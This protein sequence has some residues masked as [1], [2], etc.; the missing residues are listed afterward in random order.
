MRNPLSKKGYVSVLVDP[1]TQKRVWKHPNDIEVNINGIDLKLGDVLTDLQKNK[2][3][4]K[5]FED[6]KLKTKK[7]FKKLTDIL[8]I[9]VAQQ[10]IN[11]L[12]IEAL[13]DIMQEENNDE[14]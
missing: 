12:G 11:N 8:K 14:E 5:E 4:Q 1:A 10:E 13:E 2:T 3:T 9:L 6:Y 7:S